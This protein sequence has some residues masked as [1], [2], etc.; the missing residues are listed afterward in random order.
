MTDRAI[1]RLGA[2]FVALFVLLALRQ[3]WLQVVVGPKL[4]QN[5]YNPR[6]T[7]I[8]AGRGSI[9]A[10][11]GTPLAVTRGGK[12]VYPQGA[13]IAQAVGYASA[14]YGPR[15]SKTRSIGC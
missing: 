11:D 10:S 12:R 14:R 5:Q 13:L 2:I 8:A 9:L 15:G 7:Q 1:A 3:F 6:H 4:A